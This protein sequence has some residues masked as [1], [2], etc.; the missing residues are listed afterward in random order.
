MV[1]VSKVRDILSKIR[2]VKTSDVI[3]P[4][5]HNLQTD[6]ITEL[7]NI[8]ESGIPIILPFPYPATGLED[9]ADD[10][11]TPFS[12]VRAYH[13]Y[14]PFSVKLKKWEFK[15]TYNEF[16]GSMIFT[17]LDG[18]DSIASVEVPAGSTGS[19]SITLNDYVLLEGHDFRMRSHPTQ[20]GEYTLYIFTTV[21][22]V[23]GVIV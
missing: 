4:E 18:N 13:Y 19:Y 23:T 9:Q 20:P 17:L 11:C 5:D 15:V 2:V 16:I 21:M 10:Y 6:A 8:L 14:M 22:N 3:L 12:P 7:T 1:D